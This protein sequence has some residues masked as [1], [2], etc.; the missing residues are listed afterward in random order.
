ML[1]K[2]LR[3]PTLLILVPALLLA[4]VMTWGFV[5][6]SDREHL[7]NKWRAYQWIAEHWSTV[8]RKREATQPFRRIDDRGLLHT[9]TAQLELEQ[10]Q[11]GW[12]VRL[13]QAVFNFY[14]RLWRR[15]ILTL[16]HG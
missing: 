11:Q 12:I 16:T 4:E 13:A 2:S 10:V 5:I 8:L 6:M 7:G 15:L 3:W 14:F 9:T 1:L